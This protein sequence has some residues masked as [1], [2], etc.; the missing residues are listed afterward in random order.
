MQKAG[1]IVALA[2]KAIENAIC[3]GITTNELDQIAEQ[4]IR[5]KGAI[6]SFKNYNGFP[7]SICASVNDVIIHGIPSAERLKNGD[8][9]GVDIGAYYDGFHG[10]AAVTFGVG[11]ISEEAKRLIQ[12]T[13]NSFFEGMK[14][15]VEGKRVSD[16]SSAIQ[17]YVEEQ[18]F[19]V[20][21]EFV[22]HGVG[23]ALHEEPEVPNYGIPGRG[24]RL[25]AGMTLAVEPMIN[26]GSREINVM[27]DGWTVKTADGSLSAHF[28]HS[29]AITKRQPLLLTVC[30]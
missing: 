2:H 22:G 26:A 4:L 23:S 13:E 9:I 18:G 16:I 28:E 30:D 27:K 21:R 25:Y 3:D 14:F 15:A 29:I 6:P 10:D 8:I 19:S 11:E 1:E 5:S 7:K 20:V 24:A 17:K 12:V